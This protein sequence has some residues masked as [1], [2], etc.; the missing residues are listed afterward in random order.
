[1][2]KFAGGGSVCVWVFTFGWWWIVS[3]AWFCWNLD[4]Y[5]QFLHAKNNASVLK[6]IRRESL[7]YFRNNKIYTEKVAFRFELVGFTKYAEKSVFRV[8][9]SSLFG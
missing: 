9:L 2:R 5:F 6:S 1:M 3:H 7:C 8:E 4:G